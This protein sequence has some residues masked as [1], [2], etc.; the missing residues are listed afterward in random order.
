M[1]FDAACAAKQLEK[2]LDVLSQKTVLPASMLDLVAATARAQLAAQAAEKVEIQL[3]MLEDVE[4]T[5]RG[6]PMLARDAMNQTRLLG[7]NPRPVNEADALAIY[8]RA[9]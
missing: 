9:F 7:T 8:E 3:G 4:R 6:A 2:K 5:L 1:P